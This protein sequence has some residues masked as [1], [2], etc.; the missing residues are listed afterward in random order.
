MTRPPAA[1]STP[2]ALLSCLPSP[3]FSVWVVPVLAQA[4]C[5]SWA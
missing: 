1:L 5:L 2:G 3:S 4:K